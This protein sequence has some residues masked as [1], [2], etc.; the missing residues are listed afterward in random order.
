MLYEHNFNPIP[1]CF[2]QFSH[3]LAQIPPVK[4][5]SKGHFAHRRAR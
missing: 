1:V 2:L 4:Q 3:L 5:L